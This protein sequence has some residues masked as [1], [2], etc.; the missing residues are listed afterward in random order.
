[1]GYQSVEHRGGI[2]ADAPFAPIE[3]H[4]ALILGFGH[5]LAAWPGCNRCIRSVFDF[6]N[7]SIRQRALQN[8]ARPFGEVEARRW[9][10][11]DLPP[12]FPTAC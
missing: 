7:T 2:D 11:C 9:L 5:P 3:P 4:G 8:S 1:M 6:S 10:R 12:I